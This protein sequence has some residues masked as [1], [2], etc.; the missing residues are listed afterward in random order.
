MTQSDALIRF[1][2]TTPTL[3]KRRI[4]RASARL[5]LGDKR[6][7]LEDLL[8]C[9]NSSSITEWQTISA[10]RLL[11]SLDVAKIN[12]VANAPAVRQ[13]PARAKELVASAASQNPQAW[14]LP[15][16]AASLISLFYDALHATEDDS[17]DNHS[18]RLDLILL[19]I[20]SGRSDEVIRLIPA[21]GASPIRVQDAFNLAM[22]KW[23]LTGNLPAELMREAYELICSHS[24][25]TT[26]NFRQCAALAGWCVGE[27]DRAMKDIETALHLAKN[28]PGPN[29]SCWHY[30]LVNTDEFLADCEAIRSLIAG[31]NEIP[32]IVTK[33]RAKYSDSE[34][35]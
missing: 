1:S 14:S 32:P 29:F 34:S 3:P 7:A 4:A 8:A 33:H 20:H 5:T 28:Q 26:A 24:G 13:L 18:A 16:V 23:Q 35:G 30:A 19:L 21:Q 25:E 22:A 11:S 2:T 6:P 12:D 17:S 31:G 10:M 9:I 27:K 15:D